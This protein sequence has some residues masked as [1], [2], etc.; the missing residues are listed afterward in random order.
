MSTASAFKHSSYSLTIEST[1]ENIIACMAA[2][3]PLDIIVS[4]LSSGNRN[5]LY[6]IM[7]TDNMHR[8]WSN[9]QN[10]RLKNSPKDLKSNELFIK[11]H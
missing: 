6:I 5:E 1:I 11:Y 7:P 4:G 8:G 3:R 9:M 2:S 10:A